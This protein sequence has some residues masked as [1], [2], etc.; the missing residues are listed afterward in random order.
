MATHN[1]DLETDVGKVRLLT[2]DI[3]GGDGKQF[4][5]SNEEI[6]VFLSMRD[7]VSLAAALALRTIAGN[8]AQVSKRITFLE[9]QT[10][11][12]AVSRALREQATELEKM[13]DDDAEIE[14][15]SM[16]VDIFSRRD[17][18]L[19]RARREFG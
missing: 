15:A 1:Y 19:K 3:G 8:E 16:N 7:S 5:F 18:I 13:T 6:E 11:G 10:D 9:L 2:S 17:L 14:I 4:L 12:P